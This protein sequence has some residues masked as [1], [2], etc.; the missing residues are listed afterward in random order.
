VPQLNGGD[1]ANAP[2]T[3]DHRGHATSGRPADMA[4]QRWLGILPKRGSWTGIA[5]RDHSLGH[6]PIVALTGKLAYGAAPQFG[7]AAREPAV[8]YRGDLSICRA[9][10]MVMP[11]GHL[12]EAG[13]NTSIRAI[14]SCQDL[15]QPHR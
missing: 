3:L 15:R 11:T 5:Y 10:A 6:R 4:L 9:P 2:D 13:V 14:L 7:G 12:I 8:T 1:R